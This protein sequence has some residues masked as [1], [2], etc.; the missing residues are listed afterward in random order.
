[1]QDEY[2]QEWINQS[3]NDYCLEDAIG[4][5]QSNLKE[6]TNVTDW[7]VFVGYSRSHFSTSFTE[8]F[9]ETPMECPMLAE[10]DLLLGLLLNVLVKRRWNVF[11]GCGT[12]DCKSLSFVIPIKPAEL[13]LVR[14]D[15][16]TSRRCIN[17]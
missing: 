5:L 8:C 11:A 16:G 14:L 10:S 12:K 7:A 13:L 4:V 3:I 9:G 6:I 2:Y 17:F 15:S 1:M